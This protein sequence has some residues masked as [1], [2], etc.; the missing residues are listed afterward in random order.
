M[1]RWEKSYVCAGLLLLCAVGGPAAAQG[2]EERYI[3][4]RDKAIARFAPL[5]AS[6]PRAEAD[7]KRVRA[8]LEK[9]MRAILGPVRPPGFD[10][11]KLNITTLFTGVQGV[12][13]LDG[14]LFE[15]E[16]G[17]TEMIVTTRT[18]LARWLRAQDDWEDATTRRPDAAIR[19][20]AFYTRV[21]SVAAAVVRFA[22]LPL[23]LPA[24]Q[25]VYA[26]L[27][28]RTQDQAPA[29]A[30]GVFVAAFKGERAFIA[31]AT[32][33]PMF[34]IAACT[35]ARGEAEKKLAELPAGGQATPEQLLERF[36]TMRNAIEADFLRCFAERAPSDPRFADAAQLAK[37]L[38][39]RMPAR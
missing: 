15:T 34:G 7:E 39:E 36:N 25:T 8:D 14:L 18:L 23:G 24:G 30:S 27:A 3:A 35:S 11:G 9:Q 10:A 17:D 4:A 33:K 19:T 5:K 1:K 26:I 20:E 16:A 28:G 31:N 2:S 22:E 21:A 12:G 6:D 38:Y 32:L 29:G 37:G 13:R